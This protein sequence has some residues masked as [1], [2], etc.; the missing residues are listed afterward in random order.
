[1]WTHPY[2]PGRT[3]GYPARM[4][5]ANGNAEITKRRH[6]EYPS[7]RYLLS[8]FPFPQCE[9]PIVSAVRFL[10]ECYDIF[11]KNVLL[12]YKSVRSKFLSGRNILTAP[13]LWK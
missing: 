5:A 8:P 12:Y 13:K 10:P 1:M 3:A 11:D 2:C 9:R 4:P 7:F 6:G